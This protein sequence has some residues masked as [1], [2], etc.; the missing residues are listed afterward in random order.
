VPL[1]GGERERIGDYPGKEWFGGLFLSRDGQKALSFA[2]QLSSDD[3]WVVE[4]YLPW[5]K[6]N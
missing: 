5:A 4:N 1:T 6:S 2:Y 3:I